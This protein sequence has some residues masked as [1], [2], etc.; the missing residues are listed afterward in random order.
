MAKDFKTMTVPPEMEID[1]IQFWTSFGYELFGNQEVLAKDTHIEQGALDVLCDTYTQ[2]RETTHYIKLTFQRD[3]SIKN[4]AEL[5]RLEAEFEA[6]PSPGEP[7]TYYSVS[8]ILFG[9][10]LCTVPGI[11]FIIQN[12][13]FSSR[14]KEYNARYS[15][16]V[17]QRDVIVDKARLLC[18]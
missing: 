1:A 18:D 15:D 2:V 11:I 10:L 17:N 16:Y 3:T 5:K 8:N 7:P 6:L 13:T 12:L 4:Y 9:L 14:L